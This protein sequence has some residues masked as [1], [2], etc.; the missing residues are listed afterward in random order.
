MGQAIDRRAFPRHRG[1]G[2]VARLNSESIKVIDLSSAGIRIERPRSWN[3]LKDIKLQILHSASEN[4]IAR[5][6]PVIGHVVGET[7]DHL[8]I[9]FTSMS[10]GLAELIDIYTTRHT[11]LPQ[12]PR[13]ITRL[14]CDPLPA[15]VG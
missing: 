11:C 3:F 7:E 6:I 13:T 1:D 12:E 10:P 5:M 2:I 9:A 15:R 14:Q 4:S 8:R